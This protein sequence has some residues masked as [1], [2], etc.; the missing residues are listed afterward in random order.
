M[1]NSEGLEDNEKK[2]KNYSDG[3]KQRICLAM[4]LINKQKVAILEEPFLGRE[5]LGGREINNY[6]KK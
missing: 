5:P 4:W 1:L 6:M 3:M 2:V